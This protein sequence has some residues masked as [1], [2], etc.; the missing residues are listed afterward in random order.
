MNIFN[1][2]RKKRI[3]MIAA[4][5]RLKP[6]QKNKIIFWSDLGKRYSCNP[7][8]FSDYIRKNYSDFYDIVWMFDNEIKIPVDFPEELR[9]VRY[10]SKEFLFEVAT[11]KY[12]ICNARIP[13]WFYF[14]KRREQIYIQT[15]HSSLR[16]KAIEKDAED[17]LSDKYIED[18][19]FDSS[20]ISYIVSG[21]KFSSQIFKESFWYSGELLEVG[22]PRIDYLIAQSGNKDK[23]F[24]KS[25]LDK[26][27]K[28]VLYAPTFRKGD[29]MSAYDIN[30]VSLIKVL[31]Q[32]FGGKWKVLYRLHP[33]M[34]DGVRIEDLPEYCIDM[35]DYHDM[36]ELLI[37]SDILITDYSSSMFDVTCL[38]KLCILYVSDLKKYIENERKL[39]FD[40]KQLPF[41][42]A[43]NNEELIN[44]IEQFDEDDYKKKIK[45]FNLLI[46]SFEQGD[47]CEKIYKA[48]FE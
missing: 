30:M 5:N 8:H 19:K 27:Y 2:L 36:Q 3:E 1:V 35:C 16:L 31:S 26:N 46:G 11:A 42:I 32:R 40:I 6:I 45:S 21:C 48:L 39:Y 34:V 14:I 37:L 28:Y 25:G 33:N 24:S 29:D 20:Q 9:V 43:H 41:L 17:N 15:W 38:E 7:R 13:K 44:R 23:I 22:T 4:F 10:F 18:A 12:V 47:S